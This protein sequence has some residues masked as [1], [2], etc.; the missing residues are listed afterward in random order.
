MDLTDH[1]KCRFSNTLVDYVS[2]N[3]VSRDESA[4]M[5][6]NSIRWARHLEIVVP[7]T[8]TAQ[9][10]VVVKNLPF[11]LTKTNKIAFFSQVVRDDSTVLDFIL[12]N[13]W[14]I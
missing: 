14:V 2:L 8:D 9:P 3:I 12:V 11:T 6:I 7:F 13:L 4:P 10:E 5:C 1:S